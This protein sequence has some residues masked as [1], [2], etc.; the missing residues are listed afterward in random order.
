MFFGLMEMSHLVRAAILSTFFMVWLSGCLP[1]QSTVDTSSLPSIVLSAASNVE[2]ATITFQINLTSTAVEEVTVEY[3]TLD[4]SSAIEGVDYTPVVG[5]LTIP[6][7]SDS[8]T[9]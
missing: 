8:A 7:G 5:T 2:G 6:V 3:T 9:I 4:N 1:N